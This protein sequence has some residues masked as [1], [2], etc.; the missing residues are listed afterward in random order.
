MNDTLEKM[1]RGR[2][3]LEL[4]AGE[5]LSSS[6]R[7]ADLAALIDLTR[8]LAS[9]DDIF[10]IL[11]SVVSRL[12][13]ILGVDRGSIVLK[14]SHETAA[15]PEV[16][17]AIVVASSDDATLRNHTFSLSQYPEIK[18]VFD[19]GEV[20]IIRDVAQSPL[21][22]DVLKAGGSLAFSSMALLPII[23]NGATIAVLCLKREA[24]ADFTDYDIMHAQAVAGA[25]AIALDNARVLRELRDEARALFS[26]HSQDEAKLKELTRY[27]EIF[28]SSR[29][30]MLVMDE[31]GKVLF[32]NPMAAQLSHQALHVLVGAS[33]VDLVAEKDGPAVREVLS[34]FS[35]GQYP[36]GLDL[37][38]RAGGDSSRALTTVSVNFSAMPGNN[39]AVLATLRDVTAERGMA[40]ELSRTKEFLERVIESSVDGI[41]SADL[42]GNVLVFNRSACRLFGYE[43]AE[44][45]GK[46]RVDRLYPP[47]VAKDIMRRIKSAEGG[48]VGRLTEERVEMLTQKGECVPVNLS[49]SLVMNGDRPVGTVGIFTDIRNRLAME[50]RLAEAQQQLQD[51]QRQD[52]IAE[53]A[54]AAAHELN[55]PLTSV[56]GYAEYLKRAVSG[57]PALAHAVEVIMGETQRMA[58]I[59]RKVGKITRYETKPYVGATKIVDLDRSS[60]PER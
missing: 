3:E 2:E 45:I 47:G 28:E 13:D 30:A 20:L 37:G 27:L 54:G 18:R 32:A 11:F 41:V 17:Q 23:A 8:S 24:Q 36:A 33:L 43:R 49:A 6:R 55:Q 16:T 59:V 10:E 48:G 26:A 51:R 56:M 1:N 44:V 35:H 60:T 9:R 25:T 19:S 12:A 34:G 7:E 58:E 46:M 53:I 40:R 50:A 22:T 29:D 4:A 39:R 38:M 15:N 42:R 14:Q 57:D 52:A 5:V 21:L 31:S